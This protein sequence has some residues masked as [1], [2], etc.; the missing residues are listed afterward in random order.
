EVGEQELESVDKYMDVRIRGKREPEGIGRSTPKDAVRNPRRMGEAV[1]FVPLFRSGIRDI[2]LGFFQVSS[3]G[4]GTHRP[5]GRRSKVQD[6]QL[7]KYL[8][9]LHKFIIKV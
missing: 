3:S 1:L 9:L 6:R 4:G 5:E 2:N 8:Q 7:V